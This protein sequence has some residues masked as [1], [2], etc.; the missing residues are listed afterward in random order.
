M[1]NWMPR[2]E[3][4][5]CE[6]NLKKIMTRL[7]IGDFNYNWDRGS[8]FIEFKYQENSYRMEHSV[9]NARDKGIVL[10]NGM[11]CLNE[12][13]QSLEGLCQ[14]IDRGTYN[15]ETWIAGMKQSP[16]AEEIPE[17]LEE[18]HMKYKPVGKKKLSDYESSLVDF[19]R[20]QI[21]HRSQIK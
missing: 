13:V 9:Q 1:F 10:K 15:L 7:K 12:L 19:D 14:I 21:I 3:Q 5:T 16:S 4:G 6:R 17:F 11:D 8:C 20:N 2:K 18:V